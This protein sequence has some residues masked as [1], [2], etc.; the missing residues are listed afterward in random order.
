MSQIAQAMTLR[1]FIV[2]AL[3][4]NGSPAHQ[5]LISDRVRDDRAN[6]IR[7]ELEL[8]IELDRMTKVSVHMTTHPGLSKR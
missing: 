5:E 2:G 1:R 8:E 3:R 6:G 7:A 4:R